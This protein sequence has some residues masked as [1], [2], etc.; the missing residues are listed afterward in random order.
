[1]I[2]PS[3]TH[4]TIRVRSS[5]VVQPEYRNPELVAFKVLKALAYLQ[6]CEEQA[7]EEG[8][9]GEKYETW[10]EITINPATSEVW[11][12]HRVPLDTRPNPW[13]DYLHVIHNSGRTP[14]RITADNW[15]FELTVDQREI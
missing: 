7:A 13:E 11:I 3:K 15:R 2:D 14:S 5:F 10:A 9:P 12:D 4:V 6:E 1:V 8:D